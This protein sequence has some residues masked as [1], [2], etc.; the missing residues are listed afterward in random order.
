MEM[1]E[2]LGNRAQG[3]RRLAAWLAG[4]AMVVAPQKFIHRSCVY[5]FGTVPSFI[6]P[7]F[8]NGGYLRMRSPCYTCS[9]QSA[10]HHRSLEPVSSQMIEHDFVI[11]RHAYQGWSGAV[12]VSKYPSSSFILFAGMTHAPAPF[13][14]EKTSTI[15]AVRTSEG[16]CVCIHDRI[17]WIA[18]LGCTFN[19]RRQRSTSKSPTN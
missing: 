18:Y 11:A 8:H 1:L 2:W 6:L 16:T 12:R 9:F 5:V 7:S 14:W 4:C 13:R 10:F 19:L 15:R 17:S 3:L